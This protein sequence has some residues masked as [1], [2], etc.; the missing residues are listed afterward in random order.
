VSLG[1][2]GR[3]FSWRNQGRTRRR[4]AA[5]GLGARFPSPFPFLDVNANKTAQLAPCRAR[6]ICRH[7]LR[8]SENPLCCATIVRLFSTPLMQNIG[9]QTVRSQYRIAGIMLDSC[10]V[11]LEPAPLLLAAFPLVRGI[12]RHC[13]AL[14]SQRQAAGI[15]LCRQRTLRLRHH[16][17]P[18]PVDTIVCQFR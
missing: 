1:E 14:S 6:I 11:G 3:C 8:R 4:C 13:F 12:C 5:P 18:P 9:K 2:R 17:A 15:F 10:G 16:T 7:H